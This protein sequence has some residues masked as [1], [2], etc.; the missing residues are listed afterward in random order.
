METSNARI[1]DTM[2]G[3]ENHGVL[4]AVITVKY[5]PYNQEFGC[6]MFDYDKDGKRVGRRQCAEF[7]RHVLD[8]LAIDAWEALPGCYLRVKHEDA[9]IR[10]IGHI[11]EDRWFEPAKDLSSQP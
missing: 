9:G 11:T 6:L 10:A 5:G 1:E 3:I 8:V 7:I 2:L 4:T